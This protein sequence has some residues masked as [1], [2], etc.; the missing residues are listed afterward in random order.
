MQG[1]FTLLVLQCC[2]P[3]IVRASQDQSG[4][5]R[6]ETHTVLTHKGEILSVKGVDGRSNAELADVA[7][8]T[9][10]VHAAPVTDAVATG[11]ET[12]DAD[13]GVI[14][15]EGESRAFPHPEHCAKAFEIEFKLTAECGQNF[16]LTNDQIF[17][18]SEK[19]SL[20]IQLLGP[21]YAPNNHKISA[22]FRTESGK[23]A[24]F[25]GIKSGQSDAHGVPTGELM[26]GPI[27]CGQEYACSFV[28]TI[29]NLTLDCGDGLHDFDKPDPNVVF[30]ESTEW[31]FDMMTNT[32]ELLLGTLAGAGDHA[33]HGQLADVILTCPTWV[34]YLHAHNIS[35]NATSAVQVKTKGKK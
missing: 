4:I 12:E 1:F 22:W 25:K 26:V 6:R 33:L 28:K 21:A 32:T 14:P 20:E 10:G 2:A 24:H 29:H 23:G 18:T 3:V 27:S 34:E 13:N 8:H 5:V 16:D 11:E 9:Q 30:D 35:A 17:V 19:H 31:K 15:S 7:R